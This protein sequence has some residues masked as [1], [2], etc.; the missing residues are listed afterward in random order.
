MSNNIKQYNKLVRDKIPEIIE[1]SG[2]KCKVRI[3]NENEIKLELRKKLVEEANEVL[4]E[5]ED[6][7]NELADMLEIVEGIAQ[8]EKIDMQ[9]IKEKQIEKHNKRGGFTKGLFLEWAEEN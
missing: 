5:K 9:T 2:S 6:L 4:V 8:A 7:I 1:Q 3:L